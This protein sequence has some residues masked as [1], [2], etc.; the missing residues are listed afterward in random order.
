MVDPVVRADYSDIVDV[1][2]D[3]FDAFTVATPAIDHYDLGM[4]ILRSGKPVL[5]EKPVTMDLSKAVHLAN[6]GPTLMGGHLFLFHPAIRRVKEL[7]P[8]LGDLQFIH[9]YRLNFGQVWTYEDVIWILMPHDVAIIDYLMDGEDPLEVTPTK[10]AC[11]Q[12]G[13]VDGATAT[14]QYRSV[15]ATIHANWL[16]PMKDVGLVVIGSEGSLAF[17]MNKAELALY[18]NVVNFDRRG[19]PV[20]HR[21]EKIP[22]QYDPTPPLMAEMEYF[23]GHTTGLQ[24]EIAGKEN[25]IQVTRLL[26]E[27]SCGRR[28]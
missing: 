12:P 4:Y 14:L 1:P 19:K 22:V 23:M 3:E 27:I 13:I 8:T 10:R 7:L 25:I 26:E 6:M 18:R 16:W 2:M 28:E 9:S 24:P 11:L 17:D 20:L 21:G 5:I 15:M